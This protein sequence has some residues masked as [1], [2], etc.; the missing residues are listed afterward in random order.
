MDVGEFKARHYAAWIDGPILALDGKTP[1]Q[2]ARTKRGRERIDVEACT[3]AGG[4]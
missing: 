3:R 4:A 1:R 2:A